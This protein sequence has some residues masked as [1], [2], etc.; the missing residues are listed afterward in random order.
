[1]NLKRELPSITIVLGVI[2]QLFVLFYTNLNWLLLNAIPDDAYYYFQIAKNIGIGCG[3]SMDCVN[4]TNGYHPLW[5]LLIVPI[6]KYLHDPV[7]FTL[8]FSVLIFGGTLYFLSKILEKYTYDKLIIS[9]VLFILAFNPITLYTILNGLETSLLLFMLTL[10]I[11]YSMD[12]DNGSSFKKFFVWGL[13]GGLLIL[14]RL[15]FVF[16]VAC[17][18]FYVLYKLGLNKQGIKSAVVAGVGSLV[19]FTPFF[20]YNYTTYHMFF[21]SASLTS[22]FINH[23]LTYSDN[24]G[25]SLFLYVKTIIYMLDRAMSQ[26]LSDSGAPLL[27]IAFFGMFLYFVFLRNS[28]Y[29]NFRPN[30]TFFVF[31]GFLVTVFISAGLRWTFRPW[32]FIPLFIFTSI[33]Y[34]YVFEEIRKEGMQM[35]YFLGGTLLLF[36][37]F[38]YISWQKNLKDYQILQKQMYEAP[39]WLNANV[40]PGSHIGVFNAGI[41]TYYSIHKV[42]NLDGLVNNNAGDAMRGD[43]LWKYITDEH[44]DY[45][46]DFDSYMTY[47]YKDSFGISI[48]EV[49]SHLELV[50]TIPGPKDLNVYRV[51]Y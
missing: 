27:F 10:Y 32:Y 14:S 30:S 49:Y 2:F 48:D 15:D 42:T 25:Y 8:T 43:Y 39:Q 51:K 6:F 24:G 46:A 47:R 1:M 38:F 34:V 5:M 7:Y 45:I 50:H 22:T 31:L 29:K 16:V 4:M 35:K 26:V 12:L 37:A 21:T 40:P 13:I 36:V 28:S 17:S 19:F 20:Y 9:A 23:R 44:I 41:Q 33:M 11:Y 18:L 3:S